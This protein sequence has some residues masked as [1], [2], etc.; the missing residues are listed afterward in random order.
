MADA[1][2]LKLARDGQLSYGTP[3]RYAAMLRECAAS[4]HRGIIEYAG[5]AQRCDRCLQF[6]TRQ[7]LSERVDTVHSEGQT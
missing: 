2:M 6:I 5:G 3:D 1:D 7:R 4:G